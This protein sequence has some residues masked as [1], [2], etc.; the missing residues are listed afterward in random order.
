MDKLAV[1]VNTFEEEN[2][3]DF[4]DPL[5]NILKML[6]VDVIEIHGHYGENPL[7]YGASHIFL[8]GTPTTSDF[9]LSDWDTQTYIEGTYSWLSKCNQPVMGLCFG[10]QMIAQL[11]GGEV[12]ALTR[13]RMGH[14]NIRITQ[15]EGIFKEIREL[16]GYI[17][18][19]DYVIPPK[20]FIDMARYNRV[21]HAMKHPKRDIYGLQFHPELSGKIGEEIIKRFMDLPFEGQGTTSYTLYTSDKN[22]QPSKEKIPVLEL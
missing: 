19:R 3:P 12:R 16:Q 11:F 8:S 17:E 21:C 2:N 1:V 22:R 18:H 15:S 5:V 14:K 13:M 10:H 4:S 7:D 9:A 20:E 6:D